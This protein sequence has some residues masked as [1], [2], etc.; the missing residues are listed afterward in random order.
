M[1]I[2]FFDIASHDGVVACVDDKSAIVLVPCSSRISDSELLPLVEDVLRQASWSYRDLTHIAC[3]IGPGGFT[4]LRIAVAFA[5]TLAD[6]LEIPSTG[7]HLS[8]L[9]EARMSNSQFSIPNSQRLWLHSTKKQELFARSFDGGP[10]PEATHLTLDD[11]RALVPPH[12]FWCGELI[13]EHAEEVKRLGGREIA[14]SGLEAVLPSFLR[15]RVYSKN[16]LQPWYGR[17]F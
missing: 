4:S 2:L 6:Q 1:H 3:V 17:G 5:N 11:F 14:L 8:D 7:V 10:W 16:L 9:Y 13:L 12:F 15:E